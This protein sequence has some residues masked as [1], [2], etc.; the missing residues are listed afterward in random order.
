[1]KK[2]ILILGG[3]LMQKPAVLAARSLGCKITIADANPG[4][5]CR[6]L[7]D[8]FEHADLKDTEK[9]V[10]LA[11]RLSAEEGLAAARAAGAAV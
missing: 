6:P 10:G 1:M 8:R 11:R 7:C 9:I 4:V 3:A 2:H 5:L